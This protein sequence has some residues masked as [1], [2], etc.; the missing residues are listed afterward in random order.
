MASILVR[1]RRIWIWSTILVALLVLFFRALDRRAIQ[2]VL[3]TLEGETMGST[4][5]VRLGDWPG[6]LDDTTLKEKLEREISQ[7]LE[8]ITASLSAWD[9]ASILSTFNRAPAESLVVMDADF[10]R[11][12][13]AALQW[14]RATGGAFDPTVAPLVRAWGFGPEGDRGQPT[15]AEVEA[16]RS[17]VGV[18]H[19]ATGIIQQGQVALAK[20]R[21]GMALDV[22]GI[23]PGY[24]ADVIARL[25]K[26]RGARNFVVEVGGEV[27]ALGER[28]E[29][30]PWQIGVEAPLE[31]LPRPE[32]NWIT[33]LGL[34]DAAIATSGS[35]RN[36]LKRAEGTV[37]HII[38]PRT[39]QP[40]GGSLVAVTVKAP[41]C[42][43]A[44]AL[45]TALMVLGPEAG[46]ELVQNLG[47]VEA[48]FVLEE[49]PGQFRQVTSAGFQALEMKPAP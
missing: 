42:T 1:Q 20:H 36:Y 13:E 10:Q 29:G 8:A 32:G 24:A 45:A 48:L 5:H 30:G 7:R 4:W 15:A 44:D 12:L 35:Y 28:P 37:A 27:V 3:V 16:A 14:T 21:E 39:G 22:N 19:L 6:A 43:A 18:Q 40:V 31:G 23:A 2:P 17:L 41:D 26:D 11:V 46:L 25:L 47:G 9:P 38:D 33:V 34:K 49:S